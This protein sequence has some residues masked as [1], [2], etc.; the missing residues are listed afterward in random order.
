M[1]KMLSHQFLA[2]IMEMLY[3]WDRR[4]DV[5]ILTAMGI[6][7][8]WIEV[9]ADVDVEFKRKFKQLT[10]KTKSYSFNEW[11]KKLAEIWR[12]GVNNYRLAS[13]N[14]SQKK[15]FKLSS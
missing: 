3:M 11:L 15:V 5:I 10:K 6:K 7:P 1:K 13:P 8:M 9:S 14:D 2:T 12:G 4:A